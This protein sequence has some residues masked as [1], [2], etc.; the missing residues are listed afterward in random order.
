MPAQEHLGWGRNVKPAWLRSK[1]GKYKK[2]LC[3]EHHNAPEKKRE[4][5]E[6]RVINKERWKRLTKICDSLIGYCQLSIVYGHVQLWLGSR[7]Q[8]PRITKR[9]PGFISWAQCSKRPHGQTPK[10]QNCAY[11]CLKRTLAVVAID[12][13]KIEMV[14]PTLLFYRR[15]GIESCLMCEQEW[16]NRGGKCAK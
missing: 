8:N 2:Q 11:Y 16:C 14:E 6:T 3:N 13:T 12:R 5:E 7:C 1:N 15:A 4:I 10:P 9:K